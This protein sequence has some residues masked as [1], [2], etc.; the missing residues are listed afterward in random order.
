VRRWQAWQWHIVTSNGS[1][2][3]VTRSW[4]QQHAASRVG[5]PAS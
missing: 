3:T 2:A 4:P 1:P 5:M